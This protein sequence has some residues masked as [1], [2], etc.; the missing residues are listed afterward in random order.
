MTTYQ[1]VA[2]TKDGADPDRR[3]DAVELAVGTVLSLDEAIRWHDAGHRFWTVDPLTGKSVW[4]NKH[5]HPLSRLPFLSTSPDRVRG[6]NLLQLRDIVETLGGILG[7]A[8]AGYPPGTGAVAQALA[9]EKRRK[10]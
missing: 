5:V 2:T 7:R 9:M 8:L 4:V 10:L 6:N 3:I 1:I